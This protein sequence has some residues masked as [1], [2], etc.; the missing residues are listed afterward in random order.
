MNLNALRQKTNVRILEAPSVL[1]LDGTE[2]RIVVGSEVP[3]PGTSF[4]PSAGGTTTSIEY[5]DTGI[6]LLVQPRISASGSVT[7]N[8][9]Q[10]VSSAGAPTDEGPTFQKSSVETTL[11]VKDGE[12]VAIAGLIRDSKGLTRSGVPLL[13]DIPILGYLFGTTKRTANR[14]ELIILITP[15][16]I[17]TPEKFE[18]MTQDLKDS[19]RNVRKWA[20]EK[21]REHVEDMEDARDDR[22]KEEQER[23]RKTGQPNP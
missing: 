21:K 15:H 16:V 2:A 14:T 3:Y 7:L 11:S 1:A 6:S 5:R 18:E 4:T 12:T 22:Y 10:E 23:L 8:I 19:L 13:S 20:D 17:R 9:A